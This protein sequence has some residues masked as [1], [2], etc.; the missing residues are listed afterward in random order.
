MNM[1]HTLAPC[2][3][4]IDLTEVS[5][6]KSCSTDIMLPL[7]GFYCAIKTSKASVELPPKWE[8]RTSEEAK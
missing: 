4:Q 1:K 8:L 7:T 5:A 2:F 3:P 6:T